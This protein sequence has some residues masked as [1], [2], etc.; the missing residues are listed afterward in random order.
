MNTAPVAL[1][2]CETKGLVYKS[3]S[4]ELIFQQRQGASSLRLLGTCGAQW[5]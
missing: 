5:V 1:S 4:A 3:V 2:N